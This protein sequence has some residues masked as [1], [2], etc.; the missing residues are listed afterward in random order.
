MKVRMVWRARDTALLA[1]VR[2]LLVL[3]LVLLLVLLLLLL[4]LLWD[5]GVDNV[6]DLTGEE[7]TLSFFSL[8]KS[9]F[10]SSSFPSNLVTSE[11]AALTDLPDSFAAL[12]E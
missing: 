10:F 3:V 4:L 11:I 1:L 2:L 6:D 7:S 8:F 9:I 5:G 12:V